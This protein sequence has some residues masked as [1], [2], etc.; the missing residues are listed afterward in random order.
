MNNAR[1][2]DRESWLVLRNPDGHYLRVTSMHDDELAIDTSLVAKIVGRSF[3]AYADLHLTPVASSGSSNA[4]FRLG[5]E[6]L[7]R[8]PRQPGGSATIEKEARWLPVIAAGLT[9]T[10]PEVVALGQPG[11]GYPETWAITR[12]VEGSSPDMPWN[13]SNAGPSR[14]LALDLARFIT[15]LRAIPVPND[16][17]ASSELS[18]YRGGR[19]ADLQKDFHHW[20]E[21]CR[22]LTYLDLDLDLALTVWNQAVAAEDVIDVHSHWF[23][24]D[25][26]AENLLVRDGRLAAVLDFGGLGVGNGT[27]DLIVAWEVLDADGREAFW[28]AL[29][30]DDATR[31]ASMGWALLISLMTFPYYW[32]TMPTRCVH[33]LAMARA[34]L[35]AADSEQR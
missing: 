23:H 25:L 16:A 17:S 33:R 28:D 34:A 8:L 15:E 18:W 24:G 27:V 29:G 5:E 6:L 14:G 2:K 3:P 30:V 31:S 11:I 20:L 4:L 19:L 1:I 32:H 9:T 35:A 21:A 26:L 13:S 10:V 12:W 7:V 22:N